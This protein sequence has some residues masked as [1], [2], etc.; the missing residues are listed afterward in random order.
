MMNPS[1]TQ[2]SD[3]HFLYEARY[4]GAELVVIDPQYTATA[5]HADQWVPLRTGTDAALGMCTARHIWDSGAID[6][7]YV[8][9]QTDLPFLVR[10]DTGRFLTDA[11]LVDGGKPKLLQMWNPEGRPAGS[12]SG[13]RGQRQGAAHRRR[14][15]AADRGHVFGE[16]EGR[17][18]R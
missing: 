11:D 7:E 6:L 13:L 15:R 14:V 4:N 2:I 16:A 1:V 12:G 10:L 9:E 8:R 3:A 18:R 17:V 5:I